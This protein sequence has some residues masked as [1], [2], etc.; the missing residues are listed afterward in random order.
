MSGA[1]LTRPRRSSTNSVEINNYSNSSKALAAW[2]GTSLVNNGGKV[3]HEAS[4]QQ[5]SQVVPELGLSLLNKVA[6]VNRIYV[7]A[8]PPPYVLIQRMTF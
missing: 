1:H 5:I 3:N 6:V 2:G 8:E 7:S 4:S